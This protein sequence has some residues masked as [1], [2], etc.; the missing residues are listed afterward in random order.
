M[1][2][3]YHQPTI[4][5]W[6]RFLLFL[7][8]PALIVALITTGFLAFPSDAATGINQTLSF[9]GRLSRST[10]G[11]VPDGYYNMQFKIYQDGDG[12]SA[13]DTTGSPAGSLKWTES[14]VNNN[15]NAGVRV[16]N[17]FFSVTLG[18]KTA[19]GSSIDWNQDTLWLSMN[20]AG[21]DNA[22]TT[23]D[24]GTCTADGEML[25]MKRITAA[26]YAMNAGKLGG[27]TAADFIQNGTSAQTAD[28]NISGT[29]TANI[30]Q[31]NTQ[32]I[33]P[34]IDS[35]A[36]GTLSVG[37]VAATSINIGTNL[38]AQDINIGT[39]AGGVKNV[40]IGSLSSISKTI[41]QGGG[42]GV[43]LITSTGDISL[44]SGAG[45]NINIGTFD[46]ATT[47]NIA[48][49]GGGSTT[50]NVNIGSV[51]GSGGIIIQGG[52]AGIRANSSGGFVV[53]SN[54]S[55]YDMLAMQDAGAINMTIGSNS[56]FNINSRRTGE[57]RFSVSDANAQVVVEYGTDLLVK[58]GALFSQGITIQG[59]TSYVSPLGTALGTA[60]N[61]PNKQLANFESI[62]SFGVQ[63]NSS[64]SARGIL[65]AD[66][67]TVQHQATI[68][69]LSP[70]ENNILGF[71]WN[72]SNSVGYISNTAN[73][74][75][76]QGGGLALLTATKNGS[77]ANVGIGNDASAGY[78]LDVTGDVNSSTQ[79][80]I[81]GNVAL[82]SSA[83]TFSAASA[84]TISSAS[85]QTLTL[86]GATG[87]NIKTGSTVNVTTSLTNI[88]IGTGSG[89]GTP[90]LLTLDKASSAPATG[91]TP[92]GS[93]YYDST[94]KA[95]QCYNGASWGSCDTLPDT[96]VSLTP[97]YAG[98]VL[99][100]SGDG[101]FTAGLCSSDLNINDGTSGQPTI[102]GAN[103]TY[104]YYRW[105]TTN[106]TN[107]DYNIFVSYQLPSTFSKF[108]SGSTSLMGR[109]D[110]TNSNVAY[111]V[112]RKANG[113]NLTAC[114][115]SQAVSSGAQSSWQKTTASGTADPANCSFAAGDTIFLKITVSAASNANAYV[116]PLN[117]AFSNVN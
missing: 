26:P 15:A 31:G 41:I 69:V 32:I 39:S 51:L 22:C 90:M 89:T 8:V 21:S 77:A 105:T 58:S 104:N 2:V 102:C 107:Q 95:V 96:F 40:T 29:G 72:G 114:G 35:D 62:M 33:T 20:V 56:A 87:V 17:G 43:S 14:Y 34:A 37:N 12:I 94:L 52:S 53:H 4:F 45:R 112:Y 79:Y 24:S 30:L 48:T 23:F 80:R 82:S 7:G 13:G 108:V 25:P 61:I 19:F 76:L 97:E 98:A 99:Q 16:V 10:G 83:L 100:G 81:G 88:Q 1:H 36:T 86:N 57:S 109:T 111:Q 106:A 55:N 92:A 66:A 113:G 70:D 9:Q 44:Q 116:G 54:G 67:R 91:S 5:G 84:A 28:F 18:S 117:F 103:E 110:S 49:G 115:S 74:L 63:G 78:A 3:W 101:T 64:A 73:S 65:I 59:Q 46:Q 85:G 68:G 38:Y 60:I 71:S 42:D 75:A 93:M 6:R 50:Q 47:V 11:I 27:K